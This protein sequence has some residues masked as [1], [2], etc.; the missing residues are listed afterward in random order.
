MSPASLR[1]RRHASFRCFLAPVR[2]LPSASNSTS[3][4]RLVAGNVTDRVAMPEP[5]LRIRVPGWWN[6]QTQ[7][8]LT[9]LAERPYGFEARPGHA[10]PILS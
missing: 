6:W 10:S 9:L 3:C 8:P 4:L 1:S 2:L 5:P 7:Q